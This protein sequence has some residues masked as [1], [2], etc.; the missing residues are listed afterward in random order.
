MHKLRVE[1]GQCQVLLFEEW[2]DISE[3]EFEELI[4]GGYELICSETTN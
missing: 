2:E 1:N 3:E 4:L